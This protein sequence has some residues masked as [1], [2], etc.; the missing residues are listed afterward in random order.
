MHFIDSF[1]SQYDP[2]AAYD[3]LPTYYMQ[4][5]V[6]D[7]ESQCPNCKDAHGLNVSTEC[8]SQWHYVITI[9]CPWCEKHSAITLEMEV[10]T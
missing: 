4:R 10:S 8:V 3:S 2:Q 1:E 9:D 5:A 7:A 6:R